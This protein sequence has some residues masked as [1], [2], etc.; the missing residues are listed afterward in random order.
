VANKKFLFS[1]NDSEIFDAYMSA[2]SHFSI[3]ALLEEGRNRSILYSRREDQ[4]SLARKLSRQ[5]Y[6][7]K[8]LEPIETYFSQAA[9]TDK[10]QALTINLPLSQQELKEVADQLAGEP[11]P[12]DEVNTYLDGA[13]VVV[14]TLY[15]ETDYTKNR[16][17]QRI[18][19][20]AIV[21]LEVGPTSTVVTLPA[22]AKGR[23]IVA[24]LTERIGS[25]RSQELP[26]QEI[27]LSSVHDPSAR[28]EFFTCL[29]SE[30]PNSTLENVSTIKLQAIQARESEVKDETDDETDDDDDLLLEPGVQATRELVAGVLNSVTL[31]GRDLFGT[32]IFQQLRSRRFYIT[33][34]T[35]HCRL[36]ESG[37]PIVEFN[38]EFEDA[39]NCKTF[40]YSANTWR[41]RR[42]TG[43]YNQSFSSTPPNQRAELLKSLYVHAVSCTEKILPK[44]QRETPV[45]SGKSGETDEAK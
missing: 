39:A 24:A 17:R 38:A 15:T 36:I 5:I 34:L 2:P 29:A 31:S 13:N 45:D 33:S 43:E 44:A 19:R 3:P 4:A 9:K 22:T 30:F 27:D 14:N 41:I 28:S 18:T 35:W 7:A 42:D 37:N 40:R 25:R 10:T 12:G 20:Q 11:H 26:V 16:F 21:K 8:Q 23:E 32:R 6:G 1:I